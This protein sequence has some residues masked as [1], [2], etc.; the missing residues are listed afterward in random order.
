MTTPVTRDELEAAMDADHGPWSA[1]WVAGT[2]RGSTCPAPSP[3]FWPMSTRSARFAARPRSR[4][5]AGGGRPADHT[6]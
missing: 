3:W 2:A 5:R 6:G 1:R 4:G